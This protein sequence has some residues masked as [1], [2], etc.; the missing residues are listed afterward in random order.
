MVSTQG[1]LSSDLIPSV[2]SYSAP[3]VRETPLGSNS[4]GQWERGCISRWGAKSWEVLLVL[5]FSFVFHGSKSQG[6][7]LAP[8]LYCQPCQLIK[9]NICFSLPQQSNTTVFIGSLIYL[10]IDPAMMVT[11]IPNHLLIIKYRKMSDLLPCEDDVFF[12]R[13]PIQ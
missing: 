2:L 6:K 1:L 13:L 9:P 7:S 3:V 4:R 10:L 5:C 11:K 8:G 12:C